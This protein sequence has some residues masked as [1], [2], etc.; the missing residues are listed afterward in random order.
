MKICGEVMVMLYAPLPSAAGLGEWPISH[1]DRYFPFKSVASG[2]QVGFR[3]WG[4]CVE[5]R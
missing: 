5:K 3:V 1:S 2:S 4:R